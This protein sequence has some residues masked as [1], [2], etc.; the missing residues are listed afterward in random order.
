MAT[1]PVTANATSAQ[2]GGK[3]ILVDSSAKST[4]KRPKLA[5]VWPEVWALVYPRR[6]I[7]LGGVLLL[8]VN[9]VAALAL[10]A[11]TKYLIDD[12]IQQ[13]H[14]YLLKYLVGGVVASTMLQAGT[15]FALTQMMSK[16]AWV[17]ITDLRIKV[18]ARIARLPIRYYDANRTGTLVSRIMSDVEGIRNLVGTGQDFIQLVRDEDNR[19]T[20]GAKT[21]EDFE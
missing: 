3:P 18:Q 7:M 8:I 11:S 17:L 9:R 13:H 16:S 12:V 19:I 1:K 6:W 2:S 15:S 21:V 20:V 10:P 5:N 14:G 4:K